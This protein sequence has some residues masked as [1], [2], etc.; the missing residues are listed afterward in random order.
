MAFPSAYPYKHTNS[1]YHVDNF[2]IW[3]I[4]Q[5]KLIAWTRMRWLR[6]FG[7]DISPWIESIYRRAK[8]RKARRSTFIFLDENDEITIF[9][10]PEALQSFMKLRYGISIS[11]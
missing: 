10:T 2:E 11:L 8:K 6:D 7:K 1:H 5:N 9:H 3:M 4:A